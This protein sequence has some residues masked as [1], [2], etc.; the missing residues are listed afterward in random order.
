LLA[1]T[2]QIAAQAGQR[3]A[4]H[5]PA[6]ADRRVA[7]HEPDARPIATVEGGEITITAVGGVKVNDASVTA[8]DVAASNGVIHVIDKVLVPADVNVSKL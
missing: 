5:M 3:L 2:R 8:T 1:A 4:G 7:L 6:G